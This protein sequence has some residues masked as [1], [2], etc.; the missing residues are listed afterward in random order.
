M[1]TSNKF[2]S[3]KIKFHI[4]KNDTRNY[5]VSSKKFYIASGFRAKKSIEYAYDL[6][7]KLFNKKEIKNPNL[8]KY[9]NIETIKLF[10]DQNV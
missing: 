10:N 6:F 2:K 4:T 8:K 1:P 5:K 7:S 3:T 9:S